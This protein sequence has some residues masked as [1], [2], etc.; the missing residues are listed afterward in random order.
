LPSIID[1]AARDDDIA[2]LLERFGRERRRVAYA[3][4]HRA[5]AAGELPKGTDVNLAHSLLVGPIFY[6][7]LVGHSGRP[8]RRQLEHSVARV[9]AGMRADL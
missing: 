9:L 5:V 2:G 3:I 6:R 1:N 8:T 4:L 7:C